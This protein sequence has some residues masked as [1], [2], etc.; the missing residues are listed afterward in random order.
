[1]C[2]N[3]WC[4]PK[5]V[6]A[7]ISMWFR[8]NP[9]VHGVPAFVSLGIIGTSEHV[10]KASKI[11]LMQFSNESNNFNSMPSTHKET[12]TFNMDMLNGTSDPSQSHFIETLLDDGALYGGLGLLELKILST[13]FRTNWNCKRNPLPPGT[14]S[15][16]LAVRFRYSL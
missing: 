4:T 6:P 10:A 2:S 13:Y 1:M 15:C 12:M 11:P 14:G 8:K 9:G 3:W 5:R 16:S 7:N